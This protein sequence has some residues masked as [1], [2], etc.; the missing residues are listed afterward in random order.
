M[1]REAW[2]EEAYMIAE[3]CC[4]RQQRVELEGIAGTGVQ[5][6]RWARCDGVLMKLVVVAGNCR[7]SSSTTSLTDWKKVPAAGRREV[8][9]WNEDGQTKD[10][11]GDDDEGWRWKLKYNEQRY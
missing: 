7:Q 11:D 4:K 9:G 10:R 2:R 1:D 3:S 6:E 5:E 8:G